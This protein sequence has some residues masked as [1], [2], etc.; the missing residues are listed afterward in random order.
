MCAAT[1]ERDAEKGEGIDKFP[2][3]IV[4]HNER[5]GVNKCFLRTTLPGAWL[6]SI[7]AAFN[8]A[9]WPR[10]E[11]NLAL[12]NIYSTPRVPEERGAVNYNEARRPN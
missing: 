8:E 5:V 6:H 12:I 4:C 11:V 3:Q 2:A 9:L 7:S 10:S 1:T